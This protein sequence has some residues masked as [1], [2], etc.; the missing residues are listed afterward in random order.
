MGRNT[1]EKPYLLEIS[2][3]ARNTA[4]SMDMESTVFVMFPAVSLREITT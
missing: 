2:F 1:A 3:T 4:S